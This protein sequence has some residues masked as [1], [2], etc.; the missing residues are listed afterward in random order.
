[1]EKVF[2]I[3]RVFRNEGIDT[4]HNPEFTMLE[5]YTAHHDY[6]DVMDLVEEL[7]QYVA[8]EVVG[9]TKI[10]YGDLEIELGGK[11]ERRHMVDLI[12]DKTGVDFWQKMSDEEA[13]ALA[14]E[15]NVEIED[16]ATFGHVINEFFEKFIEHELVQPTFVYGHPI[17]ISPL[18]KK[19]EEDPRFTDRLPTLARIGV[20]HFV[21]RP[22]GLMPCGLMRCRFGSTLSRCG[23]AGCAG[24]RHMV[25]RPTGDPRIYKAYGWRGRLAV[26][27]GCPAS[28]RIDPV[29]R[30][31]DYRARRIGHGGA[32]EGAPRT[33]SPSRIPPRRLPLRTTRLVTGV[34]T[35][36]SWGSCETRESFPTGRLRHP[37]HISVI[38]TK[39]LAP[40]IPIRYRYA[41]CI[42]DWLRFACRGPR[43]A[44]KVTK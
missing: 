11:W 29:S 16:Y 31:R 4:T 21:G 40:P 32:T 18:A 38:C 1:M 5:L 20:T 44:L 42:T 15:H 7:I 6:W 35:H 8:N 2:E 3:G 9:D 43:R 13:R 17:E 25:G 26:P 41:R 36:T 30:I 14:K 27:A 23:P 28:T 19:N 12:K 39:Q 10:P 24:S 22:F 34:I 33:G 37:S